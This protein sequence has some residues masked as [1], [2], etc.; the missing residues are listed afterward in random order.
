MTASAIGPV[1]EAIRNLHVGPL[2]GFLSDA[3]ARRDRHLPT[4]IQ[5]FYDDHFSLVDKSKKV[6]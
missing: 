3:L 1:K 5:Q 6:N 4:R 2:Q